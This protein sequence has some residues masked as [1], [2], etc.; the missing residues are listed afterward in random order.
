M[1][2]YKLLTSVPIFAGLLL[3]IMG[4]GDNIVTAVSKVATG[5]IC[6]LSTNEIKALNQTAIGLGASQNPP[7]NIP[8][9]TDA[10]AQAVSEFLAQNGLCTI[11]DIEGLPTRLRNGEQFQGQEALA[12]AFGN[13]DVSNLDPHTVANLLH[14]TLGVGT[15]A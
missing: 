4:C 1:K 8:T 3:G 5:Q 14:S 12:A 7:A 13:T 6:Q 10:Q 2:S 9:L 11:Q 15:S